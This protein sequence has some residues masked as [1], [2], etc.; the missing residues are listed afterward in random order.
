MDHGIRAWLLSASLMQSISVPALE[1]LPVAYQII[2]D[3]Y[4]VPP[5]ILYAVALT[6]S[7]RLYRGTHLPWPWALNIDGRSIYCRSQEEALARIEQALVLK[8]AVDVGVMQI[9]WRW[10]WYRFASAA[11]MLTPIHNL[12]VG[13]AILREQFEITSQWWVAVGRY[14]DPGQ[15]AASLESAQRYRTRVMQHWREN[16]Q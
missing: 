11:Q 12:K 14:H 6:E 13:A 4:R 1:S 16:F 8:K 10:H 7:G 9:S 2:S 5:D 3:A 15:D